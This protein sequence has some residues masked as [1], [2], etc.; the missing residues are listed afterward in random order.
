MKK[1]CEFETKILVHAMPPR[2]THTM[3]PVLYISLSKTHVLW[4]AREKQCSQNHV[5]KSVSRY[6]TDGCTVNVKSSLA[7]KWEE[8]GYGHYGLTP[9]DLLDQ[10]FK[11]KYN[12]LVT[13]VDVSKN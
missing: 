9:Q 12:E 1:V 13:N 2:V 8:A 6:D 11:V 10:S 3:N 5:H 7:L 4:I